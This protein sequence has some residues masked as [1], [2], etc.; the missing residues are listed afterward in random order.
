[1]TENERVTIFRASARASLPLDR[2][3]PEKVQAVR[4]VREQDLARE[5]AADPHRFTPWLRIYLERWN[6]LALRRAA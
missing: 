4:W 3:D 5:V 1:M 6:E 2:F